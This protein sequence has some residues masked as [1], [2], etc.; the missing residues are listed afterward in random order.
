MGGDNKAYTAVS[1]RCLNRFSDNEHLGFD[2]IEAGVDWLR[3]RFPWF[4]VPTVEDIERY[5]FIA[6]VLT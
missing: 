3:E 5:N 4:P 2:T 1:A 6:A